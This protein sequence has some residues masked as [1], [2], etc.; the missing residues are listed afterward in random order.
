MNT[1]ASITSKSSTARCVPRVTLATLLCA[2]GTAPTW[3]GGTTPRTDLIERAARQACYRNATADAVGHPR[4]CG[5]YFAR[6][7]AA[8]IPSRSTRAHLLRAVR[9]EARLLTEVVIMKVPVS[10]A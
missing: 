5:R 8:S 3:G 7:V 9:A 2:L 10:R 6:P 4:K 1:S